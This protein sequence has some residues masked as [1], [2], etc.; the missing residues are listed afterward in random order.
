MKG[1]S[2]AISK[3]CPTFF[4]LLIFLLVRSG[5]EIQEGIGKVQHVN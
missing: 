2:V 4:K 1:S 3:M 5:Q